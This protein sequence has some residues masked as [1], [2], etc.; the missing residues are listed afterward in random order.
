MAIKKTLHIAAFRTVED[1]PG[2]LRQMQWEQDAAFRIGLD[3][4]TQV[5]STDQAPEYSVHRQI[6]R[7][8][9]SFPL[10]RLH[11]H[12]L[13]RDAAL[14][15]DRIFVRY[16]P[17]DLFGPALPYTTRQ[18]CFFV[19]HTKTGEYL[20][21]GGG[22]RN[23]YAAKLDEYIGRLTLRN[24]GGVV[25]VTRELLEY[26]R[27][28]LQVTSG[29]SIVYPN[30]IDL[31]DES[32][33]LPDKR[34]GAPKIAFV[35]SSFFSWNGLFPLLKNI[36]KTAPDGEW[37]LHLVGNC[38][39]KHRDFVKQH[40]LNKRVK[41]HGRLSHGKLLIL[42]AGMD[43]SLGAFAL[44]EI[45]VSEAC[46]L[47]VRESLGA[48]LAV[49]SGHKDCALPLDFKYY[50]IG[51]PDI[52]RILNY[53]RKMRTESRMKIRESSRH[54]IEKSFLLKRMQSKIDI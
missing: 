6:P 49:Y 41:F 53:A 1:N 30:G 28:R 32:V 54:Y 50:R 37:E 14:N 5:W 44:H 29:K 19:F 35:A 22:L 24:C 39:Q 2:V 36:R 10:R 12:K 46:T 7:A 25:G 9:R 38:S 33:P 31:P 18:K 34:S 21:Q 52:V 43:L 51:S 45:G 11:F 4:E 15:K 20:R 16:T 26:E 8:Y 23:I 40:G 27:A 47:K 48:G 13:I 17:L 42:L 3:W